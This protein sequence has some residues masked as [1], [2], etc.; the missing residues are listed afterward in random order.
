MSTANSVLASARV[1]SRASAKEHVGGT[2]AACN[3][4]ILM[5][6]INGI[7]TRQRASARPMPLADHGTGSRAR[8]RQHQPSNASKRK[9]GAGRSG[10]DLIVAAL[11]ALVAAAPP[12][13]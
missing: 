8:I 7:Y 12:V 10:A 2:K 1:G 9:I 13:A 4:I 6:T 11:V 5:E 3:I